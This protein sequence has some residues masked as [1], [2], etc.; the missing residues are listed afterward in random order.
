MHSFLGCFRRVNLLVSKGNL[1]LFCT[2]PMILCQCNLLCCAWTWHSNQF[3][4][5]CTEIRTG[6]QKNDG[7]WP[8]LHIPAWRGK[9][10]AT[11]GRTKFGFARRAFAGLYRVLPRLQLPLPLPVASHWDRAHQTVPWPSPYPGDLTSTF[12]HLFLEKLTYNIIY[13]LDYE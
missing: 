2:I 4:N 5:L 3:E 11:S 7:R 10:Q 1:F 13:L 6:R 9:N 8:R 12:K